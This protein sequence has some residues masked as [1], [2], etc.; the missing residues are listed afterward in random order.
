MAYPDGTIS[1]WLP[2]CETMSCNNSRTVVI[3]SST[4]QKCGV[5]LETS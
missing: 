4:I 1:D 3:W 5:N 2:K